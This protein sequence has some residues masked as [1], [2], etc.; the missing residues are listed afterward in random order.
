MYSNSF[1]DIRDRTIPTRRELIERDRQDE[2]II[3]QAMQASSATEAAQE[4]TYGR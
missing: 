4:E 1:E 3:R 2:D